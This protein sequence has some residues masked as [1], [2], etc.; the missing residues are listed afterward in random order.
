MCFYNQT[1]TY[2]NVKCDLQCFVDFLNKYMYCFQQRVVKID[3]NE[4]TLLY[5]YSL[6]GLRNWHEQ[7]LISYGN[8]LLEILRKLIK[9]EFLNFPPFYRIKVINI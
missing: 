6:D 4:Y 3:I 9:I 5:M 1:M 8:L 7:K 2:N